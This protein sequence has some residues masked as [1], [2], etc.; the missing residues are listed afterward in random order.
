MKKERI[1]DKTIQIATLSIVLAFVYVAW[2][3]ISFSIT[4][5]MEASPNVF[6]P[7]VGAMATIIGAVTAVIITQ[8]QTKKREIEEA[9]RQKKTEIY[10]KFLE[11]VLGLIASKN[12]N[13][14]LEGPSD[15]EL[16]NYLFLYKTEILLWGSPKVIKAQLEFEAIS[17]SGGNS[18]V[19]VDKV[20]RAIRADI[21]L[22]NQGLNDLDLIK[23]F[24]TDPEELD[25]ISR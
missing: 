15:K 2:E 1:F 20:Y 6:A 18:L 8:H 7:L 3:V 25:K 4:K 21:G 16:V 11:T 17:R 22:T 14:T 23:L 13:L 24:L 10:K 19:A 9:H 12:E 5:I